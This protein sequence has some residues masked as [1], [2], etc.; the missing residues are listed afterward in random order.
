M[1]DASTEFKSDHVSVMV[2]RKPG[3]Q[4]KMDIAVTPEAAK[5]SF[6]KAIK[7]VNKEV[8]VPGFR[9][10]KASEEF[11]LKKYGKQVQDEW[12]GV[13]IETAFQEAI[14][15]S[16]L[17]PIRSGNAKCTDFKELSKES[18]AKL[19][20]EFEAAPQVPN[21]DLSSI[22]LHNTPRHAVTAADID[23]VVENIRN[24]LAQWTPVTDRAVEEGDYVDLTIEK[25][26]ES[27]EII[28]QDTRFHVKS[29]VM[30]DWMYRLIKG[31]N[32]HDSIEGVSELG[33]NESIES[34]Q[35]TRCQI[36][37][38]SIKTAV[39][40]EVDDDLAK[41]VGAS[42]VTDLKE[43]ITA[44][45]NRRADTDMHEQLRKQVDNILLDRYQFE[46]PHTII[47][48]EKAARKANTTAWLQKQGAPEEIVEKRLE[49][50]DHKLPQEVDHSYRLFFL[51]H[52][53][54]KQ[55]NIVVTR[56]EIAQELT[57]QV[58]QGMTGAFMDLSS[59][60]IQSR[61]GEQL[62]LRKTRDYIIDHVARQ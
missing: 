38:E 59:E 27:K 15:L 37:I 16:N 54:A 26:D 20:I 48:E 46:L 9:K 43:K 34:F 23:Q 50:L 10:G 57:Q 18:G 41:K 5:A 33:P 40:P 28:C 12:R 56:E 45:L 51:Y 49:E 19:T 61:L 32:L 35:P 29:G 58:M 2:T 14:R 36:T 1:S 6:A 4:I 24:H 31:A 39:L 8:S 3:S 52:T 13:V 60:Q 44:D 47:E 55:H 21:I 17:Y 30:A 22:T 53:F 11:I 25:L 7:A 62:L 42:N